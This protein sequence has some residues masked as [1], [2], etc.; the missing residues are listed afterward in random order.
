MDNPHRGGRNQGK[1]EYPEYRSAQYLH[2]NR[3]DPWVTNDDFYQPFDRQGRGR[4]FFEIKSVTGDENKFAAVTVMGA[5][6]SSLVGQEVTCYDEVG[7]LLADEDNSE[8]E[9]RRGWATDMVSS[10]MPSMHFV[11]DGLC[12]PGSSGGGNA[13]GSA[14]SV[15]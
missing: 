2:G 6:A 10:E 15:V 14:E 5:Q 13:S 7:C 9:G 3:H 12:C 11:I 1:F 8:L 4:I